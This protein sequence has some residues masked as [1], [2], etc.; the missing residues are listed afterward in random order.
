M[1]VNP[2]NPRELIVN[3]VPDFTADAV[4][5]AGRNV[6]IL[7]NPFLNVESLTSTV[8]NWNTSLNG[9]PPKL[10]SH[11]LTLKICAIVNNNKYICKKDFV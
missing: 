5:Y 10:S 9:V 7:S 6:V 11:M 2:D 4:S 3:A 1:T 8:G